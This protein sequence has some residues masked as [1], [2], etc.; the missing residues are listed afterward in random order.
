MILYDNFVILKTLS[1]FQR[2][3][4]VI[5]NSIPLSTSSSSSLKIKLFS[6]TQNV[7][8]LLDFFSSSHLHPFEKHM[9]IGRQV[10]DFAGKPRRRL[11][12]VTVATSLREM[13]IY[14][15]LLAKFAAFTPSCTTKSARLAAD[16]RYVFD[17]LMLQVCTI[18]LKA[19]LFFV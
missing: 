6:K 12:D 10:C 17:C 2:L 8:Q 11:A 1:L 15:N 16:K 7:K 9:R 14:L 13:Q 5:K 19:S 4:H 18:F 3:H